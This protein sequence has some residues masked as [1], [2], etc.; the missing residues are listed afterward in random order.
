MLLASAL[1]LF[2]ARWCWNC[3]NLA[4]VLFKVFAV[5]LTSNKIE[6]SMFASFHLSLNHVHTVENSNLYC[7]LPL[8]PTKSLVSCGAHTRSSRM[9]A[10]GGLRENAKLKKE[11]NASRCTVAI[12]TYMRLCYIFLHMPF[13]CGCDICWFRVERER[14]QVK[15]SNI[16]VLFICRMDGVCER[17]TNF[18][19][20][21]HLRKFS[22]MCWFVYFV[23]IYITYVCTPRANVDAI[24]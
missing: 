23:F 6:A 22:S 12:S 19:F 14:E 18:F 5:C 11:E 4:F 21:Q 8:K 24:I 16:W 20:S 7:I 13:V 15:R 1:W 10:R 2:G 17:L 9:H 3:T